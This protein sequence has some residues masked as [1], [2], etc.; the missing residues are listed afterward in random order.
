M[1]KAEIKN[2][3]NI[4]ST[5]IHLKKNHL[6]IRYAMNGTGKS[7]I[8]TAIELQSKQEDLSDLKCFGSAVE[9][10]CTFSENINKVLL[11]NDDFVNNIVFQQSEVIQNSFD[12]FIRTPQ[13]EERQSW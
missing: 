2:C 5:D 8:A 12:V 7:T 3:N 9:P 10:T 11:F 1:I 13:Y 4:I 6:N